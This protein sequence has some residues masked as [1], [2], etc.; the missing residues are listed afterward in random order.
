MGPR[1]H[2]LMIIKLLSVILHFQNYSP[3]SL[4][5]RGLSCVDFIS[6]LACSWLLVWFRQRG[7]IVGDETVGLGILFTQSPLWYHVSLI[8]LLQQ[9]SQVHS[10]KLSVHFSPSSP[11]SCSRPHHFQPQNSNRAIASTGV[12]LVSL[13]LVFTFENCFSVRFSSVYPDKHVPSI[14]SL[15]PNDTEIVIQLE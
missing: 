3:L 11:V 10:R 1:I 14:S 4:C 8:S 7:T 9:N 6:G 2:I 15:T 12:P 5:P 13:Y